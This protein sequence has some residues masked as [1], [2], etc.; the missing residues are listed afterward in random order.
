MVLWMLIQESLLITLPEGPKLFSVSLLF[1]VFDLIAAAPA[2]NMH[3][4]TMAAIA[5]QC[6]YII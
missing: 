2:L 1:G 5:A 4:N 6:A 3:F